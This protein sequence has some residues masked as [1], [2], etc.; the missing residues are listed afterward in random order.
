MS[1]KKIKPRAKSAKAEDNIKTDASSEATIRNTPATRA[2]RFLL[3]K[4]PYSEEL[5]QVDSSVGDLNDLNDLDDLDDLNDLDQPSTQLI[6]SPISTAIN[7]TPQLIESQ[8]NDPASIS[9]QRSSLENTTIASTQRA[10]SIID[11]S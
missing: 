10:S 5:A 1:Q 3:G 8:K 11:S 7:P 4:E 9:D 2:L 6:S